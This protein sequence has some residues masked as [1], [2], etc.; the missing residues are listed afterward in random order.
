MSIKSWIAIIAGIILTGLI[1]TV[2]MQSA[3]IRN[4]DKELSYSRAN[5]K[6]LYAERDSLED[7]SRTLYLTV[8]QLNQVN[9]SIIQKMNGM[10]RELGIKDKEIQQLQYQLS[11]AS[12]KDTIVFRDTLFRDPELQIDTTIGD[13]WY[14]IRLGLEY[15]STIAV[16]PSFTSERYVNMYLKKET[17]NPPKKCFIAR[18]FQKKHLISVVEVT[19]LN[20]YIKI[21][22]QRY[23]KAYRKRDIE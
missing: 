9:D 11:E 21:K 2:S 18:W 8:E 12:K 6:A 22:E 3:R 1:A 20:P 10:R 15:P 5:E 7:N 17:V 16:T 4:L 13:K 14:N 23:I 19:E